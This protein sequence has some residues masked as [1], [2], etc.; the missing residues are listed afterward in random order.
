MPEQEEKGAGSMDR[1]NVGLDTKT[2]FFL[3]I[4]PLKLSCG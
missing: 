1:I 4:F 3:L 2:G